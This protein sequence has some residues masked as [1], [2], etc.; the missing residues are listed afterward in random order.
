MLFRFPHLLATFTQTAER[1]MIMAESNLIKA[2]RNAVEQELRAKANEE[3]EK[4]IRHMENRLQHE[5][6]II[7]G[8]V[9]NRL[10][11]RMR[12]ERFGQGVEIMV[13]FKDERGADNDTERKARRAVE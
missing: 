10:D 8:Q 11:I 9:L 4:A 7:I 12:E 13:V 3:I 5:K 1:R 6:D 2:V